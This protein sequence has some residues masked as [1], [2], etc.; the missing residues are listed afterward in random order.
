MEVHPIRPLA[1]AYQ[2]IKL[3]TVGQQA[4]LARAPVSSIFLR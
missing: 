3:A 1:E 4:C 2:N